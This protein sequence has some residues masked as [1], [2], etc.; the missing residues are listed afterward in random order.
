MLGA[1]GDPVHAAGAGIAHVG[2]DSGGCSTSSEVEAGRWVWIDHGGGVISRYRHLDTITIEEGQLVTPATRIGTM[3]HSGDL[4]PCQTT[5]LH[6]EVLHDAQS[7][8][9][10]GERVDLGSLRGCGA[11]GPLQLPEALGFDSW[12]APGLHPAKRFIS[13]TLDDRCVTADRTTT[14]ASPSPRLTRRDRSITVALDVPARDGSWAV[15]LEIWRPTLKAWRPVSVVTRPAGATSTVFDDVDNDHRY[16]ARVA[17]HQG[18]GWSRWSGF[19]EVLGAPLAPPVRYLEW[20]QTTSST[21][22]Y[23]HYGWSEPDTLGGPV[24]AYSVARRCATKPTSLGTWKTSTETPSTRFRNIDG[25]KK[26]K[27]CEVRVR[28]TNEVGSGSWSDV[29]RTTR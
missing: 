2:G 1:L 4:P 12:N 11:Q 27:V 21:K 8:G 6:F 17:L 19:R 18:Q 10:G 28:A 23:L 3:G 16:R 29:R 24:T 7:D 15:D 13:P 25:L 26:A 5:Y 20:K 22:S 14:P 9:Q